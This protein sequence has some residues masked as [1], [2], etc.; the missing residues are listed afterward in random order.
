MH[1]YM[2]GK[3]IDLETYLEISEELTRWLTQ[4]ATNLMDA[5]P[6]WE[7]FYMHSHPIDWYYHAEITNM[8]LEDDSKAKQDAWY[9]HKRIF[10]SEDKMVGKLMEKA[11]EDT[12]FA[13]VSDHGATPD[14][15][16]FNPFEA[17]IAAG[18][19]SREAVTDAKEADNPTAAL[20]AKVL[21]HTIEKNQFGKNPRRSTA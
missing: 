17:L 12:L 7:L 5:I 8:A 9:G 15:T 11:G 1:L 3:V 18:L 6:D 13:I 10:Q 21:G 20:L 19:A 4:A 14:G 2:T 16:T